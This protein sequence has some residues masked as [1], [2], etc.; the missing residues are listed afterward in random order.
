M[1][2]LV[3]V[4]AIAVCVL[5]AG[6]PS[7][8]AQDQGPSIDQLQRLESS[9]TVSERADLQRALAQLD[10]YDG[11]IDAAFGPGTRAAIR[12]FQD[13][14]GAPA[15]GWLTAEQI[16]AL[17]SADAA[18]A[19]PPPTDAGGNAPEGASDIGDPT[20]GSRT[21]RDWVGLADTDD[22]YAVTLSGPADI[23]IA[24]AE[25]SADADLELYDEDGQLVA[26][27]NNL[28]GAAE[29]VSAAL[30]PGTYRVRV[31]A[32][33]GS[34]G[35]RLDVAADTA[36]VNAPEPHL[37]AWEAGWDRNERRRVERALELLGY[38]AGGVDG[39]FAAQTR[40]AIASFQRSLDA[41]ATATLSRGQRV[42]LAVAAAEAAARLGQ[43]AAAM[44]RQR[45]EAA[46]G[47]AE[48]DPLGDEDAPGYRGEMAGGVRQGLGVFIWED[49]T[50]Y[51][52]QFHAN[53]RNGHGIHYETDGDRY[54]GEFVEDDRRGFGAFHKPDGR[55]WR[56]EFLDG[57]FHG[58]G[59]FV[60]Q[61]GFRVA[62]EWRRSGDGGW[63]FTGYGEQVQ[64]GGATRRG[65][66]DA[67]ELVE[68]H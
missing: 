12:A 15:S 27:S 65:L 19:V 51:E 21:I 2:R 55:V 56:G 67:S 7:A 28:D 62:G 6:L 47:A 39:Y 4:I 68:P 57:P 17:L 18:G 60:N 63:A 59:V 33:A 43:E 50:R 61:D 1:A 46:L 22:Y 38:L 35:Y 58:F 25:L 48:R 20:V 37:V 64:P 5:G 30:R 13:T 23:T 36:G 42:A 49:G 14:I 40:T 8:G 16:Q 54:E 41:E 10:L 11:E 9:L 29:F 53:R 34:T 52:G 26:I 66:W 32:F 3:A 24:L 31:F 45:S 44:G